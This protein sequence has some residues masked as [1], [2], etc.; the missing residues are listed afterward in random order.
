LSRKLGEKVNPISRSL[1]EN[2]PKFSVKG[3]DEMARTPVDDIKIMESLNILWKDI[4]KE[5]NAPAQSDTTPKPEVPKKPRLDDKE[6][7]ILEPLRIRWKAFKE[8]VRV[9]KPKE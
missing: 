4:E 7:G 6:W 5:L 9:D 8:K 3:V 2:F 1:N